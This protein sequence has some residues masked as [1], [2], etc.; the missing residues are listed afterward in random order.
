MPCGSGLD[1]LRTPDDCP[2]GSRDE[3]EA[4]PVQVQDVPGG[5]VVGIARPAAVGASAR[6]SQQFFHAWKY[7]LSTACAAC[8]GRTARKSMS[9]RAW[10]TAASA[11]PRVRFSFGVICSRTRSA[12]RRS[13]R[14]AP[15]R[16]ER[17][18]KPAVQA[19]P[20][21]SRT[22]AATPAASCRPPAGVIDASPRY[23][24]PAATGRARTSAGTERRAGSASISSGPRIM[25][26]PPTQRP[27]SASMR[28]TGRMRPSPP[29]AEGSAVSGA[30]AASDTAAADEGSG[31]VVRGLRVMPLTL[32]WPPRPGIGPGPGFRRRTWV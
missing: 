19:P 9:L 23:T 4:H 15:A 1:A 2:P 26:T 16:R 6:P 13:S 20:I 24:P 32:S 25:T 8:A 21:T 7:V 17:T 29:K 3:R 27:G 14:R 22:R 5:V 30:D 18:T 10:R 31:A 12:R 28:S 11:C